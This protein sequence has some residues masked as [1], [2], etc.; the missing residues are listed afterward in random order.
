MQA[1]L[2]LAVGLAVLIFA[3]TLDKVL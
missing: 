1:L 2:I 3:P